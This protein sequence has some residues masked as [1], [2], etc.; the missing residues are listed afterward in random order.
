MNTHIPTIPSYNLH[1]N[2]NIFDTIKPMLLTMMMVKPDSTGNNFM[3]II[4]SLIAMAFVEWFLV[5]ARHIWDFFVK[6]T[7]N[8]ITKK[9]HS[10]VSSNITNLITKTKTSITIK[11]D[12][13]DTKHPISHAI[14]DMLTNLK[15]TKSIIYENNNFNL[16]YYEPIQI[17]ND[18]YACLTN[19]ISGGGSMDGIGNSE[20]SSSQQNTAVSRHPNNQSQCIE[21]YS[22]TL[23]MVELRDATDKIVRDYLNKIKNKLGNQIFYFNE[24]QGQFETNNTSASSTQTYYGNTS[25][26]TSRNTTPYMQFTMKPFFTNR[27]FNNVFG[28][29]SNL[30]R[31]RVEFFRDNQ[32]WYNDKGIPY[33]L[34]ILLSGQAGAGKTST[35]K[36]LSNEL[37]RH[38]VNISFNDKMTKTQLENLFYDDIINVTQNGKTEQFSIPI[39]KRIYVLEDVDCESEVVMERTLIDKR[40]A[41]KKLI[42][43]LQNQVQQLTKIIEDANKGGSTQLVKIKDLDT[44]PIGGTVSTGDK[45][46]L[47]FLLNLLDGVLETPGRILIM[48]SNWIE[49]LDHALIRPGRFDITVKF[50]KCR[51]E[52]IMQMVSHYYDYELDESM[53]Q[54]IMQLDD[55]MISPAECSKLLFENFGNIA[56]ALDALRI[57]NNEKKIEKER[58]EREIKEKELLNSQQ[59]ENLLEEM[60]EEKKEDEIKEQTNIINTNVNLK[61]YDADAFLRQLNKSGGDFQILTKKERGMED[62]CIQKYNK[63]FDKNK[64]PVKNTTNEYKTPPFDHNKFD[65]IGSEKN[66][67]ERINGSAEL[68]DIKKRIMLDSPPM[69]N[70]NFENG[71]YL[72]STNDDDN[73]YEINSH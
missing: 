62:E 33:T 36:C 21:I 6:F 37:K 5:N 8:F 68:D 24:L 32:K 34:G 18:M 17:T 54:Q 16:N 65:N 31:K 66:T 23:N 13:N 42:D 61:E 67:L 50:T 52:M 45:I 41:D 55:Y 2:G 63:Q 44:N 60:K 38:I 40:S 20:Q 27:R 1:S 47:S 59:L 9:I 56:G 69:F 72:S 70:F 48:T 4:W 26:P 10:N 57:L 71:D 12:L 53:V 29:E 3:S 49:K 25:A 22:Y 14:T 64:Q 51:R 43:N 11:L 39:D 19:G 35:I 30:I 73:Y 46:T 58:V 15:E 7:S 28:V